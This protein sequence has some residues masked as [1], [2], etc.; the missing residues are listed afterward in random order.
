MEGSDVEAA[1]TPGKVETAEQP[2]VPPTA[3]SAMQR[4][5][6]EFRERADCQEHSPTADEDS[7][8]QGLGGLHPT[9]NRE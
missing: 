3:S 4:F 8:A 2:L 7:Q 9:Q 6:A 1:M 5:W